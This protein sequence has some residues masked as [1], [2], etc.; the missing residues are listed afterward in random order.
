MY[1]LN[2]YDLAPSPSDLNPEEDSTFG[3]IVSSF[4][5]L[6]SFFSESNEA[7]LSLV[8]GM[9]ESNTELFPSPDPELFSWLLNGTWLFEGASAS[10]LIVVTR[11]LLSSSY[12]TCLGFFLLGA[13]AKMVKQSE[14]KRQKKTK[15]VVPICEWREDVTDGWNIRG[16]RICS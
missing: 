8:S 6:F 3:N 13:E 12:L 5:R 4:D 16:A 11:E 2:A 7:L 14:Q 15:I 10:D 9:I 1:R